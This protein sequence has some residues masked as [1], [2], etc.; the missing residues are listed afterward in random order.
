ML[1]RKSRRFFLFI[2]FS[3]FVSSLYIAYAQE[4]ASKE[5]IEKQ[6]K[7]IEIQIESLVTSLQEKQNK[8]SQLTEDIETSKKLYRETEGKIIDQEKIVESRRLQAKDRLREIQIRDEVNDILYILLSS[9][10]ITDFFERYHLM[11]QLQ[12]A[13]NSRLTSAQQSFKDLQRLKAEHKDQ[14][15]QL[16]AQ[17]KELEEETV[18]L[19]EQKEVLSEKI[20]SNSDY[21]DKLAEEKYRKQLELTEMFEKMMQEQKQV[22]V[23]QV[24]TQ[25]VQENKEKPAETTTQ[26]QQTTQVS[27]AENTFVGRTLTVH[28]TAY[29]Y[30][31]PGLTHHTK[32]G[33]DLRINPKVIAVDPS[34]IP[35]GSY[36]YIPNFG[37]YLAADVGSAIKG[38]KIDI[39]MVSV[40]DAIK[41]GRQNITVTILKDKP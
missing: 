19:S 1:K 31:E 9:E 24:T 38:N 14:I 7:D 18:R 10:S 37:V 15:I 11:A 13:A 39:H 27:T 32:M 20:A 16:N 25:S 23:A 4:D 2:G 40:E 17:K 22:T 6:S 33:I 41:F 3:F 26:T 29:S 30:N 21:L 5:Q 34:V 8:V 12:D 28:A 36:V 35:L